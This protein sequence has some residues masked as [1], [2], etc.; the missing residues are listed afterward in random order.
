MKRGIY[1]V[2]NLKSQDLC[3]N[4]IYSIR[5]TGCSLPIRLIH[6]GGKK[7]NAVSILS[8]VEF[9]DIK[10]FPPEAITFINN[11]KTVLNEYSEGYLYRYLAWF[12]D[13]DEFIYSDN[14]I[15]ALANWEK[16][17]EF[18]PGY[19]L[20]HGDEEYTT[21]GKFDYNKPEAL[22][23]KFGG[24]ALQSQL[25]SGQFTSRLNDKLIDDMSNAVEWYKS[26][27]GIAKKNDQ[28]FLHVASLIGGWKMLNLCKPPNNWLSPWAYDYKNTLQLIHCI[29]NNSK[30]KISHI[31][32]SGFTP[33][34]EKPIQEFLFSN[35]DQNKRLKKIAYITTQHLLGLSF[36]KLQTKRAKRLVKSFVRNRH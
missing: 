22:K 9:L 3:E 25:T 23:E 28:A 30:N 21:N 27:P 18:M 14:D 1:L 34:G 15:V 29:Q 6:F 12:G 24:H 5:N 17:F 26:N 16:L 32:Y 10:D 20:V 8:Q 2:A 11:V 36:L 19:D 4:L 35:I 13:W 33:E 31:H 7:I